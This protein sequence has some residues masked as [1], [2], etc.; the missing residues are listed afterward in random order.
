M[1]S[2]STE[3][4]SYIAS[5]IDC[6]G[7]ILITR[8]ERRGQPLFQLRVQVGM[9]HSGPTSL[10][11]TYFNCRQ[12]KWR[13]NGKQYLGFQIQRRNDVVVFLESIRPFSLIKGKQMDLAL[14]YLSL[15]KGVTVEIK[16]AFRLEMKRLNQIKTKEKPDA[17]SGQ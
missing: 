7:S 1:T 5:L 9:L 8:S 13:Q 2:I 12:H 11:A 15:P 10:V 4:L 3:T 17:P 14:E 16:E 6:E